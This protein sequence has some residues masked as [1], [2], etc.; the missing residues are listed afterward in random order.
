MA[1]GVVFIAKPKAP[2]NVDS[3]PL[4][5]V[6]IHWIISNH[7]IFTFPIN[8]HSYPCAKKTIVKLPRHKLW[9]CSKYI[10]LYLWHCTGNNKSRKLVWIVLSHSHVA[11]LIDLSIYLNINSFDW[12]SHRCFVLTLKNLSSRCD[13]EGKFFEISKLFIVTIF[14]LEQRNSFKPLKWETRWILTW[15]SGRGRWYVN[16]PMHLRTVKG[17]QNRGANSMHF[18]HRQCLRRTRILRSS[19]RIVCLQCL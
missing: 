11:S 3:W 18:I 7:P 2:K 9:L 15:P 6:P 17:P 14:L 10:P 13:L 12:F 4:R 5:V 1:L 16:K 19:H 8:P